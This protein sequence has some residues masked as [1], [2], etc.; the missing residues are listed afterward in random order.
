MKYVPHC[1][2]YFIDRVCVCVSV[3][4]FSLI[5]SC[6]DEDLGKLINSRVAK[7]F[8]ACYT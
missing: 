5:L 2:I 8:S 7:K 1:G 6:W 3:L 4:N